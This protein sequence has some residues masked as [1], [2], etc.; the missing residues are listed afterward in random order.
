[1]TEN[2][3]HLIYAGELMLLG[4]DPKYWAAYPVPPRPIGHIRFERLRQTATFALPLAALAASVAQFG[5]PGLLLLPL[6]MMLGGFLDQNLRKAI[7]RKK[8]AEQQ[9]DRDR[10]RVTEILSYELGLPPEKITYALVRAMAERAVELGT[11]IGEQK[12]RVAALARKEQEEK[13]RA[14][15][16]RFG[17]RRSRSR[18]WEQRVADEDEYEAPSSMRDPHYGQPTVNTNG[19]PM[20]PGGGVD[21]MGNVYG[22]NNMF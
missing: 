10:Y 14:E 13:R 22:S 6:A 1:M 19:L 11:Q 3:K 4:Q 5:A 18:V 9:I 16:N 12:A 7:L 2:K 15:S 8:K 21:V 17:F 20:M